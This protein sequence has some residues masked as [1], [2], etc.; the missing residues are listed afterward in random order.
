M[1]FAKIAWINEL[2][3]EPTSDKIFKDLL[4]IKPLKIYENPIEEIIQKLERNDK[5]DK[6]NIPEQSLQKSNN[7]DKQPWWRIWK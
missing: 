4:P 7:L 2:E 6:K 5:I 3:I 1:G